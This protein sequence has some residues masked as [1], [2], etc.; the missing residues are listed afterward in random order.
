M[1]LGTDRWELAR[2]P[3]LVFWRLL[4]TGAGS[5]TTVGTADLRRRAVFAVWRNPA[6]L[7]HFLTRSTLARQWT[8]TGEHF[9]VRLRGLSGSG[10][11]N[12]FAVL[13]HVAQGVTHPAAPVAVLTRATVAIRHWRAFARA[14]RPVAN[15]LANADGL[16][17]VVGVGEAPVLRQATF[18]LW[19]NAASINRFAYDQPHHR[20]VIEHTRRDKWY[21]EELFIRFEPYA[22]SGTWDG[23]DPLS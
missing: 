21:G 2:T 5:N 10:H 11:W 14:G 8:S 7:D 19:A 12:G 20:K 6:D 13:G 22:W 3:G 18:S 16:L 9:C 1:H 4:G 23:A 17:G 15:E